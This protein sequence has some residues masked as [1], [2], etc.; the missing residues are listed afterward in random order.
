MSPGYKYGEAARRSGQQTPEQ[1]VRPRPLVPASVKNPENTVRRPRAG[2]SR[3]PGATFVPVPEE[4]PTMP[5]TPHPALSAPKRTRGATI[6]ETF[7]W[8][9]PPPR[10]T[11]V[12][13]PAV[14]EAIEKLKRNPGQ[15][16][17][18]RDGMKDTGGTSTW[19]KRGCQAATRKREDGT[20]SVWA[21][22]PEDEGGK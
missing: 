16:A 15:W 8:E 19:I 17:R 22:W 12:G 11:G 7:E 18:V 10:T 21:R 9:D 3:V 1:T 13:N 14:A 6:V 2:V 20:F 5:Q 4:V